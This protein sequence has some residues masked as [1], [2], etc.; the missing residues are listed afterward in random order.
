MNVTLLK[1]STNEIFEITIADEPFVY[2]QFWRLWVVLIFSSLLVLDYL[3]PIGYI[4]SSRGKNV[5]E[6]LAK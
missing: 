3:V 4:M 5:I 6:E 1:S 2:E